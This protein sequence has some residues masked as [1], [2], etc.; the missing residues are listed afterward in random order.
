[1]NENWKLEDLDEIFGI[2]IL[3]MHET[4]RRTR[5]LHFWLVRTPTPATTFAFLCAY[6]VTPREKERRAMWERE[7]SSAEGKMTR[8]RNGL[9]G[10]VAGG[11][12]LPGCGGVSG[13]G[14]RELRLYFHCFLLIFNIFFFSN[15]TTI[16]PPPRMGC[17]HHRPPFCHLRPPSCRRQPPL[18]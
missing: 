11:G 7:E 1:M 14:Y 10:H 6:R 17:C 2:C 12:L 4:G 8:R 15:Q 16:F 3:C 5:F 13:A 18:P 9:P